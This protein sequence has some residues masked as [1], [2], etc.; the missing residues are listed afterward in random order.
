[1][2]SPPQLAFPYPLPDPLKRLHVYD[3][4][5]MNAR[6]WLVAEDYQRRRQSLQYQSVNQPG[7][8]CGLGV[9]VIPAPETVDAR[10]RD[11]RWIEIEPGVA[12]DL[13]GNP[14]VVD[15]AQDRTY[16]ID[17][18]PPSGGTLTVYIVVSY[19]E[20]VNPNHQQLDETIREWFRFDQI[21]DPPDGKQVEL[22]RILLTDPVRLSQ[23]VQFH[24]PQPN[25]LDFRYRIQAGTRTRAA[26]R[27]GL[28]QSN[29]FDQADL[30]TYA[31]YQRS[32]ENLT[33]LLSSLDSLYPAFQGEL[34]A[35][36]HLLTADLPS[37][38][39]L[40]L[41]DGNL[42]SQ[43]TSA[44]QET[45]KQYLQQGGGLAIEM[46]SDESLEQLLLERILPQS[47]AQFEP[48]YLD[49][50]DLD[51]VHPLRRSPFLF[52]SLADM[53]IDSLQLYDNVLCWQGQLAGAWGLADGRWLTRDAIRSA[54][55]LGINILNFFWQRRQLV[56]L[57][58]WATDLDQQDE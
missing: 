13:E 23:P 46:P 37:C 58:Q 44:E 5:M 15:A 50:K 26:L 2:V 36:L 51:R 12:I 53:P 3:G 8:V 38:D 25:Q 6:R 19:A 4:L 34:V 10:F 20:P 49:W 39:L 55:E 24:A 43:F 14:I 47:E 32:R 40:F 22:C 16:R 42:L 57:T 48:T 54:Q 35:P 41:P 28:L 45:L 18:R 31:L 7:V 52:G 11:A 30:A 9:R 1:M 33:E 56:R 21:T 27:V 17:A 29:Q